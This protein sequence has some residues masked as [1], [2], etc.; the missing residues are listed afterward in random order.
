MKTFRILFAAALLF[1]TSFVQA[2]TQAA[3]V[4]QQMADQVI[5]RLRTHKPL[6]DN[7]A[8]KLV[9]ELILPN[10]DFTSFSRLTLG[11]YW[12]QASPEQRTAFTNAFQQLLM[13]SYATSLNAY[14]GESI[15]RLGERDEGDNRLL[16]QTQMLRLQGAPVRIDYRLQLRDGRW[17][18]YDVVIEGISLIM[19]YRTSF[20][21]EISHIGLD[22]LIV[23]LSDNNTKAGCLAGPQKGC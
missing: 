2:N 17:K 19:T 12:R 9:E 13:R 16:V 7:Q 1:T 8:Y 11:K 14:N 15:E 5:E 23:K 22:A 20:S 21:E 6:D 3:D 10:L 4:V 18:I